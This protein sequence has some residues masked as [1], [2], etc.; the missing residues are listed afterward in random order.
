[1]P[2]GCGHDAGTGTLAAIQVHDMMVSTKGR[3]AQW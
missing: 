1:M 3:I 2:V